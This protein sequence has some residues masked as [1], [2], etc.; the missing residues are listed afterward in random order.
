MSASSRLLAGWWKCKSFRTKLF[1]ND[2]NEEWAVVSG[3]LSLCSWEADVLTQCCRRSGRLEGWTE[4]L[5]NDVNDDVTVCVF[6]IVSYWQNVL[7]PCFWTKDD[8]MFYSCR[9]LCLI[10]GTGWSSVDECNWNIIFQKLYLLF[11]Y[12][13]TGWWIKTKY[14]W[15]Q[16]NFL[17]IWQ[18]KHT[19]DILLQYSQTK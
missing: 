15:N 1:L 13:C 17:F 16:H 12:G 18:N 4:P 6:I 7:Y 2:S 5:Q 8:L 3:E 19:A 14:F 11:T 10:F 9:F